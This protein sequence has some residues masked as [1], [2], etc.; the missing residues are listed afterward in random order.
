MK[1]TLEDLIEKAVQEY[2]AAFDQSYPSRKEKKQTI[3]SLA[4]K[5]N[6]LKKNLE[7]VSKVLDN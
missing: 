5:I 6:N 4:R 7:K 3:N 1:K 2:K